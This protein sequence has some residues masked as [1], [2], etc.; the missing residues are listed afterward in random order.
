M[1]SNFKNGFEKTAFIAPILGGAARLAGGAVR[2]GLGLIG[3]SVKG[4]GR[5]AIKSQG[6]GLM[7][8]LGVGMQGLGVASDM[9]EQMDKM[10]RAQMR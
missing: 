2:G 5:A 4:L 10:R 7:G 6:G 9:G 8:T 3:K 1:S